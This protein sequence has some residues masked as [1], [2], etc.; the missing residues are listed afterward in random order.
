MALFRPKEK[1]N[2]FDEL[3]I[4]AYKD[5]YKLILLDIDN[6]IAIPDTG[7]CP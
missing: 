6:T 1:I 7:D 3:D 5:K 4:E 2:R